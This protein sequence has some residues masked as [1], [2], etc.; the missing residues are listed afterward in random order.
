MA[1]CSSTWLGTLRWQIKSQTFLSHQR[2]TTCQASDIS[3]K[4]LEI[5]LEFSLKARYFFS[6]TGPGT[7]CLSDVFTMPCSQPPIPALLH[8]TQQLT[9]MPGLAS[10]LLVPAHRWSCTVQK[11]VQLPV[12]VENISWHEDTVD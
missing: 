3:C 5:S 8:A 6:L 7:C 12:S 2:S 9:C 4:P 10:L 1:P 11:F